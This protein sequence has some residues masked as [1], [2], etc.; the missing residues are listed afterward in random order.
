MISRPIRIFD[1]AGGPRRNSFNRATL[2]A[3]ATLEP[4]DSVLEPFDL[5]AIAVFNQD[6]E[7]N[8]PSQVI[9]VEATD[10]RA[11]AIL[12]VT[13]Q[14]PKNNKRNM[15]SDPETGSRRYKAIRVSGRVPTIS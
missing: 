13:P 2:H 15:A 8:P 5:D 10:W 7:P 3:A 9:G 11:N 14:A 6:D 4:K 1:I 12:F